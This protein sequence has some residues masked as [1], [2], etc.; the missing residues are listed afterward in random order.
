MT[1]PA[2]KQVEAASPETIAEPPAGK[3]NEISTT[4]WV[5]AGPVS[6]NQIIQAAIESVRDAIPVVFDLDTEITGTK[7]STRDGVKGRLYTIAV[8]YTPRGE[9]KKDPVNVDAVIKNLEAPS[10]DGY[11]PGDPDFGNESA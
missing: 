6:K 2:E 4:I 5:Q 11:H 8:K 3:P 9:G 10:F 7:E 1:K